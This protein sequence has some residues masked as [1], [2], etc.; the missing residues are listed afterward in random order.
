MRR[1]VI[2]LA[3]LLMW[4]VHTAKVSAVELTDEVNLIFQTENNQEIVSTTDGKNF[5]GAVI[6][7]DE[8][9]HQ[10]TFFYQNGRKNGVATAHFPDNK[11]EH[12]I[13]YKDGRKNGPE[14][15]YYANGNPQYKRTYKDDVLNGEEIMFYENGKP[16]SRITYANGE[17]DGEV[18]YFDTEGNFSRIEHY[19]NGIKDGVERIIENNILREENNYSNGI[20]HGLSKRYTEKYL[21]EEI[22]YVNGKKEGIYKKYNTDGTR[23]EIPYKNDKKQGEGKAY[24]PDAKLAQAVIYADDAKNGLSKKYSPT[25][26]PRAFEN[27]THGKKN[28]ISRYFDEKGE[29]TS[30]TYY[31]D[32]VEMQKTAIAEN[33]ELNDLYTAYKN[34]KFY[35]YSD[36]QD[37]W[38]EILWLAINSDNTD[39]LRLLEKEMK[40]YA[41]PLDDLA[42]YK[43]EKVNKYTQYTKNLYFDQTP[44]SYLINISADGDLL[45]KFQSLINTTNSSGT[46][47]IQEAIDFN[48][49]PM[50]QYLL[51]H[52]ADINHKFAGKDVLFYAIEKG[53]QADIISALIAAGAT[54]DVTNENGDTLLLYAIKNKMDNEMIQT[55]LQSGVTPNVR[56]KQNYT[57]IMLAIE[58]GNV[59]LVE[60]LIQNKADLGLNAG[61]NHLIFFAY[62]YKMPFDVLSKIIDSGFEINKLNT[63]GESLLLKALH[64]NDKEL[65]LYLLQK[66]ADVNLANNK[67]ETAVDYVVSAEADDEIVH[68]IFAHNPDFS[69]NLITFDKPLWKVLMEQ[70]KW[71][72]LQEV[73]NK[74]PDIT[75]VADIN[76]EIP[77]QT[78]LHN[79][80]KSELVGLALSFVKEV[81]SKLMWD[82]FRRGNIDIFKLILDKNADINALNDDGESM[83]YYAIKNNMDREY[84]DLLLSRGMNI[85]FLAKDGTNALD[86][87]VKSNNAELVDYLLKNGADSQKLTAGKQYLANLKATQP[88]ITKLFLEYPLA[89]SKAGEEPLF[90]AAVRNLNIILAQ[91]LLERKYFTDVLDD[92]DGSALLKLG[93]VTNYSEMSDEE[94]IEL[95]KKMTQLLLD[96]GFDINEQNG[97]GESL[98]ILLA[99]N[100]ARCYDKLAEF[101]AEKGAL[102]NI[103]DQYGRTAE[104]Y[105]NRRAATGK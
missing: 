105:I 46:T 21:T 82:I 14:V 9:G 26:M 11:P 90:M 97:S 47:P 43:R 51:S 78:A 28:G 18:S 13:T 42:S 73:W 39:M 34:N 96:N 33:K 29:L 45:K 95:F 49:L 93:E 17:P 23:L 98:L 58:Q 75:S 2:V 86:L 77:L 19:K 92:N 27:Y 65:V 40:M 94:Y 35:K 81:D 71:D 10:M 8:D 88:E 22:E 68:E 20:L 57:P 1:F 16:M 32:D 66:G 70:E 30:V 100:N 89:E 31:I 37:L 99:K 24:Y 36:K 104:D 25:G 69:R 55:L 80:D 7:S 41:A 63:D 6:R 72:L 74:M 87:A 54:T 5:S 76:N 61:D 12:Q 83:F 56:D 60:L 67:N 64:N 48:N 62:D 103:K 15:L 101:L 59:P 50:V 4:Q 102:D 84:T 52:K 91:E 53:A 85:N 38:I 79:L 3:V 44:F